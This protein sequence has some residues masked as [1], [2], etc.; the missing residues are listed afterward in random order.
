MFHGESAHPAGGW[1]LSPSA[2][3]TASN[4]R[5]FQE[6]ASSSQHAYHVVAGL[7]STEEVPLQ[8]EELA[9]ILPRYFEFRHKRKVCS[10]RKRSWVPNL[11]GSGNVT[12]A[13][14]GRWGY[15]NRGGPGRWLLCCRFGILNSADSSAVSLVANSEV[16]RENGGRLIYL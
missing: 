15:C 13:L 16:P 8:N 12:T 7:L 11:V 5:Q 14:A 9:T 1:G 3:V 6:V 10:I 4:S 2:Q